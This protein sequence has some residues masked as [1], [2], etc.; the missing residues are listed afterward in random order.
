[1]KEDIAAFEAPL[2]EKRKAATE[3]AREALAKR[4]RESTDKRSCSAADAIVVLPTPRAAAKPKAA[5]A[6]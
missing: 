1:M 6:S 3:R 5:P 4:M 2:K